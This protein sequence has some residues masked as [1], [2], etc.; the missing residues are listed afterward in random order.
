VW[1]KGSLILFVVH[2]RFGKSCIVISR[3]LAFCYNNQFVALQSHVFFP[4]I[5]VVCE[6]IM[7]VLSLIIFGDIL[8]SSCGHWCVAC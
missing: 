4:N 6:E 3:C 2:C 7:K 1:L 8:N 5:W